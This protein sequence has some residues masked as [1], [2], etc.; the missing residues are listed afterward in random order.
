MQVLLSDRET[1]S[2]AITQ[3]DTQRYCI[4]QVC[5]CKL[6]HSQFVSNEQI[7]PNSLS[8][9]PRQMMSLD[10]LLHCYAFKCARPT[11]VQ[12]QGWQLSTL[13]FTSSQTPAYIRLH[14]S[15]VVMVMLMERYIWYYWPGVAIIDSHVD[16]G[17][18][19]VTPS[20]FQDLF[21]LATVNKFSRQVFDDEVLDIRVFYV[22]MR[23]SNGTLHGAKR[24]ETTFKRL[25]LSCPSRA[26]QYIKMCL[27]IEP[28][29]AEWALYAADSDCES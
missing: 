15:E 8:S 23:C 22:F 16:S 5:T 4:F 18:G 25:A 3:T 13:G 27:M 6:I 21:S 29:D 1:Y 17:G 10:E 24:V 2:H 11:V 26:V 14:T 12:Q 28:L 7:C 9:M 19:Q 20:H